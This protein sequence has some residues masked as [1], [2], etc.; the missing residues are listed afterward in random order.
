MDFVFKLH[1]NTYA[2]NGRTS[3]VLPLAVARLNWAIPTPL[4]Y[5]VTYLAPSVDFGE[6]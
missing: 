5:S 2:V 3:R 4:T 1:G 6:Y